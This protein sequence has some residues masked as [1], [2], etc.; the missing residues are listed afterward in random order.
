M[1]LS[2]TGKN[3]EINDNLRKYVEKKIGRLDRYL[4]NVIDGRVE[5][6]VDEGAR[7]AEDRQIA[8]V[9]LRTKNAILRAE[10][11]SGDMFASVDAVFD[12][13][14]RQADRYKRRRWAKRGETAAAEPAELEP[15]G[16]EV[17]EGEEEEPLAIARIKRFPVTPMDEVE[18]IEQMELLGHDFYVFFN[19]N[20]NQINVL[21][22]RKTG[23][24][25]LIQ[26]ELA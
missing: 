15:L 8:Q 13:M 21:Y 17:A 19:V 11:A 23:D 12:K 6:M 14:Q 26:P 7:A 5:L 4:P 25:G 10:E 3:L 24:Y 22:R 1:Q 9:T 16:E 20:A 18:A 2:I